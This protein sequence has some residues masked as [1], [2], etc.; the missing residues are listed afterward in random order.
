MEKKT[1]KNLK[2]PDGFYWGAATSAYQV[3]GGIN[4][5][6]WAEVYPAGIACDHY[7]RFEEDFDIAKS[8]GHNAHRFSIEWSRIEPEEGKFNKKEIEHY[9]KVINALRERDIEPFVTLWH[10]TLPIWVSDQ[11]G[12]A[13]KKTI[14]DFSR[15]CE[16]VTTVFKDDVKYWMVLN[17]PGYWFGKAYGS[18]K[19]PVSKKGIFSA[20]KS[21]WNLVCAQ[22][23]VYSKLKL[24]HRD[25]LVGIIESTGWIT[26]EPF[27]W[28]LHDLRNFIFPWLVRG[29][30]DFFG[31]NYYRR[32]PIIGSPKGD[33]SEI[34]W[35]IYP[36]GI[37]KM[38]KG[39][40][41]RFSKPI[42]ITENGIADSTDSKR[43]KFIKNHLYW[44]HRA[45]EEGVDVRGYLHWSLLDN[46]EWDKGFWPRFGL[47]E[48][49]YRTMER[50]IRPSAYEYKK[51][52]ENNAI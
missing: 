47:V 51:I 1:Q 48:I 36:K 43:E 9:Q 33:V 39:A 25:F 20:I 11:G 14:Y 7:N 6:D 41:W 22:R 46:F 4:N 52:I 44:V 29:H 18:K 10:W 34:G 50:K 49:D 38:I 2:F 5:C 45:M 24:I 35:E 13:N 15:Y 27:R 40:Y 30:F 21:Y 12:W 28:I 26:P 31:L 32:A 3:E 42:I 37:Y 8:L 16:R 19:F 23:V 17:E